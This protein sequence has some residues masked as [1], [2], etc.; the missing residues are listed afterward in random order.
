MSMITRTFEVDD[1]TDIVE[2]IEKEKQIYRDRFEE[3]IKHNKRVPGAFTQKAIAEAAHIAIGLDLAVR[4]VRD[5][6][7]NVIT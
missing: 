4:I 7:F 5:C 1:L 6:K 3:Y 2:L